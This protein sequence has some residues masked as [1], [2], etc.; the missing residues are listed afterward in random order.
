M[1]VNLKPQIES[2]ST[3][4]F[5]Q[6]GVEVNNGYVRDT[7]ISEVI[8]IGMPTI[9]KYL[10][11]PECISDGNT[12][13][14]PVDCVPFLAMTCMN[15]NVK[16]PEKRAAL[17]EFLDYLGVPYL[18]IWPSKFYVVLHAESNKV[19]IGNTDTSIK[20]R[21]V[22]IERFHKGTVEVLLVMDLDGDIIT[23]FED[24]VKKLLADSHTTPPDNADHAIGKGEW[25]HYD[26]TVKLFIDRFQNFDFKNEKS[27]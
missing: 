8:G 24:F 26:K 20:E 10:V 19:K 2:A 15:R 16:K 17:R 14:F 21:I 1:K 3:S 13:K 11:T 22:S 4:Y 12:G 5:Q 27:G 23:W 6:K 9:R 18:S 25:Y 7:D